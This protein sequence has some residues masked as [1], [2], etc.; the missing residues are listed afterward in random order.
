M[1]IT[2]GFP[3]RV[4]APSTTSSCSRVALW[5]ISAAAAKRTVSPLIPPQAPADSSVNIGRINFPPCDSRDRFVASSSAMSLFKEA[6][7][8][9]ETSSIGPAR[10]ALSARISIYFKCSASSGTVSAK[11]MRARSPGV[12]IPVAS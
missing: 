9:A 2:V 12:S 3:R 6:S 10:K 8:K 5:I 11:M 4:A 1:D 7:S